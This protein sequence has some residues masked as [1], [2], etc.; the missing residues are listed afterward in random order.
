MAWV[1]S[2]QSLWYKEGRGQLKKEVKEEFQRCLEGG[3]GL[4]A[5]WWKGS[6]E[7]VLAM[8][9]Q[10]QE[11]WLE[12]VRLGRQQANTTGKVEKK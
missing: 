9:V 10:D 11:R 1:H 8:R 5:R 4:A 2:N 3:R 7:D 6:L 12:L